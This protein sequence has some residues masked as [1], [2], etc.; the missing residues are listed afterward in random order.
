MAPYQGWRI[1][2]TRH[3]PC[4]I[5]FFCPT[6]VSTLWSTCIYTHT[7]ICDCV[8]NVQVCELP[9]LP[10]N[11]AVKRF[12]TNRSSAKCWLD[13]YCWGAGLAMTGAIRDIGQNVLRSA[14]KLEVAAALDTVTFC[15]LSHCSRRHT[16]EIYC[17]N[18]TMN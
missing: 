15:C 5:F 13:I 8:Q 7:H 14:F 4:P 9:L 10:N 6:S 1:H 12:Y 18:Y 3:S 2:G 17:N 11:T 16:S